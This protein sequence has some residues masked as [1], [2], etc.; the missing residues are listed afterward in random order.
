MVEIASKIVICML[1]ASFIGFLIGLL[2]GRATKRSKEG[3]SH[4]INPVFKKQGNVY[5]KPFILSSARPS[6][7]DDLTLIEGVDATTLTKL[8][9]LGIFHFD[10]IAN[11]SINNCEWVDNFLDLEGRIED[12]KWV[13]KA[14]E[15]ITNN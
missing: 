14:Q 8:N 2:V 7:A 5:Y 11:W 6:G 3:D 1:L 13:L 9:S 12:E 4:Y 10:Q 15:I